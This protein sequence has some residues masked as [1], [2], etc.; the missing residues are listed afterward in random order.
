MLKRQTPPGLNSNWLVVVWKP[1]G[2][3][4]WSKCRGSVQASQTNSRRAAKSRVIMSSRS[5]VGPV[6]LFGMFILF[7]L[8][9]LQIVVETVQAFL[10]KSAVMLHPP[11]NI[12]ERLRLKTA[13][14]P[15]SMA[16]A[17]DEFGA[18]QH[19]QMFGD[20]R[21]AHVERAGEFLDR[22]LAAGQPRKDGPA[23][24]VGQGREGRAQMIGNHIKLNS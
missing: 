1:L 16:R 7:L 9:F 24:R 23:G 13:G 3:H 20:G 14:P 5:A 12:L 19:F 6:D 10:P 22:R 11:G 2:P 15:L 18:F 21:T 4:H 17:S 8:E